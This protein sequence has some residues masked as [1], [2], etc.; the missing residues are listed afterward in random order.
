MPK[1]HMVREVE[2][3]LA[4]GMPQRQIARELG[5]SRSTVQQIL[6]GEWTGFREQEPLPEPIDDGAITER[7]PGCG[8]MVYMPCRACQ[9]RG[10]LELGREVRRLVEAA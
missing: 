6:S 1:P 9:L 8:G 5:V 3:R 4:Q 7:C 10:G 2:A